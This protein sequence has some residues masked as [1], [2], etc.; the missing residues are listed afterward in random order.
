ML[1]QHHAAPHPTIVARV[2]PGAFCLADFSMVLPVAEMSV[3]RLLWCDRRSG[4]EQ[5]P[6]A[7]RDLLILGR[8]GE[9]APVYRGWRRRRFTRCFW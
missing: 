1:T 5:Q 3:L 6:S 4:M 7:G 2:A 8:G 9:A